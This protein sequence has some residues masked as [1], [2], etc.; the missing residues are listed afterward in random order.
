MSRLSGTQWSAIS[1]SAVV[2]GCDK[3]FTGCKCWLVLACLVMLLF[4]YVVR[5]VLK[6]TLCCA[7]IDSIGV[8]LGSNE[9]QYNANSTNKKEVGRLTSMR[10]YCSS[11][12]DKPIVVTV[13][14]S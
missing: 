13:T 12:Y 11:V 3:Y 2:K 8:R 5:A 7:S 6:S 9:A 1:F 4:S 14:H 10:F